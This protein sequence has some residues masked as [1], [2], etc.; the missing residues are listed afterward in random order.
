VSL[1]DDVAAVVR[2][3]PSGCV[4]SYGDI[5]EL[6]GTGPRVVG[7][8]MATHD[9]PDLPWWRIVRADGGMAD[10]LVDRAVPHWREEG[11][12]FSGSKVRISRHRADLA[13]LADAAEAALGRLPGAGEPTSS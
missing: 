13:A 12:R 5:A 11:I 6:L 2:L 4:V 8:V 7:R 9:E 3:V 1:P 10:P